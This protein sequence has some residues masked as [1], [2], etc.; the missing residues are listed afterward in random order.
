MAGH[1]ALHLLRGDWRT[2]RD[3]IGLYGTLLSDRA[4]VRE[5]RRLLAP[6][7]RRSDRDLFRRVVRTPP[8]RYFLR[9]V[10]ANG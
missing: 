5:T 4:A 8:L 7:R 3:D 10:R 1:A 2:A 6:L 9:S